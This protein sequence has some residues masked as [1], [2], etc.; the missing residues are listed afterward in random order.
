M[1]DIIGKRV[2]VV[3]GKPKKLGS[4][5]VTATKLEHFKLAVDRVRFA[6]PLVSRDIG[7]HLRCLDASVW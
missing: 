5:P 4:D 7:H 6:T 2:N 1:V 3:G